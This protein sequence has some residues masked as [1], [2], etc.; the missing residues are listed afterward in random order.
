M[1]VKLPKCQTV[2]PVRELMASTPGE[3]LEEWVTVCC[4]LC[5]HSN[6][7][8]DYKQLELS[9]DTQDEVDSWKASLLRAGVYPERTKDESSDVVSDVFAS[10]ECRFMTVRGV[11]RHSTL[12]DFD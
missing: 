11:A 12:A 1:S 10:N 8:K 2:P 6:V 5:Y 9:A 4:L 7:Y 3:P